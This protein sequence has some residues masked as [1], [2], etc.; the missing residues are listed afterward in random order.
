[1]ELSQEI[2]IFECPEYCDVCMTQIEP[3][4]DYYDIPKVS[5]HCADCI[6]NYVRRAR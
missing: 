5:I 4:D 2:T 6:E 3:G 1:V